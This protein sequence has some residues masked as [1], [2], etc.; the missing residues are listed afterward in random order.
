MPVSM[1]EN[2][3]LDLVR[4]FQGP[5]DVVMH[6]GRVVDSALVLAL[7]RVSPARSMPDSVSIPLTET[8]RAS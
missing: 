1:P 2:V 7:G 4:L 8:V 3:W 6:G 5:A